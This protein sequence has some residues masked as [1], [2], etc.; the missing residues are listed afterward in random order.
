MVLPSANCVKFLLH[1]HSVLD[2]DSYSMS[3]FKDSV[4]QKN[5][6]PLSVVVNLSLSYSEPEFG[7]EHHSP[8]I[9][10]DLNI[11]DM[12]PRH[13][14]DDV[15][16]AELAFLD[17]EMNTTFLPLPV[18]SADNNVSSILTSW[19]SSIHDSIHLNK[20]TPH[21]ERIYMIVK[22]SVK[23]SHPAPL[24]V[25]LRKR[26]CVNIYKHQ[27]L[28][29]KLRKKISKATNVSVQLQKQY[30]QLQKQN[31][32]LQKQN[33]QL[34][35]SAIFRSNFLCLYKVDLSILAHSIIVLPQ[36]F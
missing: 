11:E 5:S 28:T 24:D 12:T 4:L 10:L 14:E 23:L 9:Y 33:V 19:D 15:P 2:K 7:L 22:A 34:Q 21:N 31:V 32:Q 17:K 1:N 18:V 20:L 30:V 29:M 16:I 35:K 27:S 36:T 13:S 8:V 3:V 25:T 6:L 26:I